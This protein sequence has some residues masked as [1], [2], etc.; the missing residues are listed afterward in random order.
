MRR[1]IRVG[2]GKWLKGTTDL[3]GHDNEPI[4]AAGTWTAEDAYE[5]RICYYHS[6]FCPVFRFRYLNGELQME[7]EPNVSW[8]PTAAI[9]IKGQAA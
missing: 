8:G 6:P 9:A 5:V 4:A 1:P 2:Y 7:V 3:R